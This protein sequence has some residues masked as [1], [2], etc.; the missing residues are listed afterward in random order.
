MVV[1]AIGLLDRRPG[2]PVD[3]PPGCGGGH[4]RGSLRHGRRGAGAHP[5]GPRPTVAHGP[6]G[7]AASLTAGDLAELTAA[8]SWTSTA[9]TPTSASSPRRASAVRST[10]TPAIDLGPLEAAR[11]AVRGR[12]GRPRRRWGATPAARARDLDFLRFQLDELEAAGIQGPDEDELLAAEEELLADAD[13]HRAAA[14]VGRGA[15]RHRRRRPRPDRAG[16][17]RPRR[18][19]AVRR[20]CATASSGSPPSSRTSPTTCAPQRSRS[21]PIRPGSR[22]CRRAAAPLGRAAPEVRQ[23]P[24]CTAGRG[25]R[26]LRATARPTELAALECHRRAGG[27]RGGGPP[28]GPRGGGEGGGGGGEAPPEG[29][30]RAGGRGAGGPRRARAARVPRWRSRWVP[31][32]PGDDV[33]FLLALNP[34]LPAAPLAKAASGGELARTML[35][36]RLV[37]GARVPDPGVRRGRCRRRRHGRTGRRVAPWPRW[38][39][40]KQVLVVTHLPQVAAFADAQVGDRQAGRRS[41]H[42]GARRGARSDGDP[43]AGARPDA[44]G[45]RRRASRARSTPR[46]CSPPPPQERGR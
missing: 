4:G 12:R 28:G 9:S 18:P 31:I 14:A 36:L 21:S 3:G 17:G 37:V 41:H 15:P 2:R 11:Q 30:P 1:G 44:V 8:A 13:A 40:D 38:P 26:G 23:W 6:T 29:G 19:A 45:P 22:S 7:T 43:G 27:R 16:P 35:A 32:D 10:A 39:S 42:G 46:S 33:R 5:G 20:R 25:A 24:A 34:G